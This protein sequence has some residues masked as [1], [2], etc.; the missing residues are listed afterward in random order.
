MS[1]RVAGANGGARVRA[2]DATFNACQVDGDT[3]TNDTVLAFASGDSGVSVTASELEPA[4]V[5]VC[6]AIARSMIADGEG[7]T[8]VAEIWVSGLATEDAARQVARTVATSL[9][10]KTALFG[11]DMNWG[12]LLAAA[13]RAG[14]PFDPERA[15]I[16]VGDV[17]IVR[18]GLAVGL[19]AEQRA[20][21][22]LGEP[23][24]RIELVLGTGPGRARYLTSDLGHG[25]VDVNA[26]YRS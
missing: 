12:R 14:V 6:D 2:C 16:R 26:G 19:E 3:S 1:R 25:Y 24:Y 22:I 23:T 8:H 9:L 10:V 7:A 15:V 4:F 17:E 13:G 11:R 20:T 5:S 21:Q 18:D